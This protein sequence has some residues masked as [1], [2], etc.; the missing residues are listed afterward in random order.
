M[1]LTSVLRFFIATTFVFAVAATRTTDTIASLPSASTTLLMAMQGR[2]LS[3]EHPRRDRAVS[4]L[5]SVE[6][7]V[8]VLLLLLK[9]GEIAAVLLTAL[10]GENSHLLVPRASSNVIENL[11]Q[12]RAWIAC[13]RN[14]QGRQRKIEGGCGFS[15]VCLEGKG[16]TKGGSERTKLAQ[17][18]PFM[19]QWEKPKLRDEVRAYESC[20]RLKM[21]SAV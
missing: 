10:H 19:A 13:V 6:G 7:A 16:E 5:S 1:S 15:G 11:L 14:A 20:C 12:C 3:R 8:A 2:T 17:N 4:R 9:S 21:R 18:L